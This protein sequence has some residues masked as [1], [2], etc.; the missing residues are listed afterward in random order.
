MIYVVIP[1]FDESDIDECL[2]SV[3]SLEGLFE[4][5]VV[6][7]SNE[8]NFNITKKNI[9]KFANKIKIIRS[10]KGRA[11][12]LNLGAKKAKGDILVFLHA[13][14]TLP[15]DSLLKIEELIKKGYVGGGFL[16]RFFE[17][18]SF[19]KFISFR[20]NLR[21]IFFKIFFGDQTIFVKRDVFMGLKGFKTIPIME[22][23]DFSKRMK[24]VGNVG[25]IKDKVITSGRKYLEHGIIKLTF[26]YFILMVMYHLKFSYSK[27]NKVYCWFLGGRE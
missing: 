13:D 24:S 23:L 21:A 3:F 16:L 27:I 14:T 22:D 8:K 2:K 26:V 20:S 9:K 11:L 15:S 25:V 5:I 6:D 18:N 4:V 12:Q 7:S 19:L 17:N 10:S 1:V